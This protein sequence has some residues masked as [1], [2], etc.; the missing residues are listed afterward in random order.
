MVDAACMAVLQC[1]GMADAYA[2]Q[3]WDFW[4]TK[5][6]WCAQS[7]RNMIGVQAVNHREWYAD[8]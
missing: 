1:L 3:S 4:P 5:V 2:S 6:T 8:S 7:R